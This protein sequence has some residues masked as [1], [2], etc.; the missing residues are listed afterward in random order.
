M[1]SREV[2]SACCH[3]DGLCYLATTTPSNRGL[4]QLV[5][6]FLRSGKVA[7]F[8]IIF[9]VHIRVTADTGTA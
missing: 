4:S 2:A 3:K 9:S 5:L 7:F 6:L 1:Y 8:I